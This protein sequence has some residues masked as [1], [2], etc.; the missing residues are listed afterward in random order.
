MRLIPLL[1][2]AVTLST[3]AHAAAAIGDLEASA[4]TVEGTSVL[5]STL[6]SPAAEGSSTGAGLFDFAMLGAL[7]LGLAGLVRM[8]RH[9]HNRRPNTP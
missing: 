6:R 2:L 9:V 1:I 8:R 3:A 4:M 5:E 7:S